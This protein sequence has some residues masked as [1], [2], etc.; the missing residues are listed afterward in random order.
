MHIDEIAIPLRFVVTVDTEADDAWSRPD[1]VSVENIK[2][3]PRFQDL[4]DEYGIVPTYLLTYEC[5]SRDDA[6]SILE[7]LADARDCE[8]GHHLHVWTCPPFQNDSG[9]GVDRDWVHAHQFL[10][11]D[12][13]F[14]E[15][16]ERLRQEI[17]KTFGRSPTSHRA[18]RW[19]V[20][21]RT[22]DWLAGSGFVVDTSLR[23]TMR[24][25]K[26]LGAYASTEYRLNRNPFIWHGRHRDAEDCES[27]IEIP[28]TVDFPSTALARFCRHWLSGGWP[29]DATVSRIYKKVGGFRMLR[30][31]PGYA[32]GELPEMMQTALE[33]GVTV[34]NLMLHSSELALGCSP[35]TKSERNWEN[36]WAHVT[37]IFAYARRCKI[38]SQGITEV[39]RLVRQ[40]AEAQ[41]LA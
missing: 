2:Q 12:S 40:H 16:A 28:A 19:G 22:I 13:L 31:D 4:C 14:V 32:P 10:L 7:P 29:M 41:A 36:V 33:D 5:A 35:F 1:H 25:P 26:S 17:E 18:G 23:P 11:P 9:D 21:Q 24:L 20:D 3:L 15:K 39:G 38:I 27:V 30:P 34:I 6:L 8:I 37:D